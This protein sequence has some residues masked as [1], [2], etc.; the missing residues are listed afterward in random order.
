MLQRRLNQLLPHV[1]HHKPACVILD[2][3]GTIFFLLII[4]ARLLNLD[5]LESKA[6][7]TRA[8]F[9]PFLL[10]TTQPAPKCF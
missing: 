1:S 8:S 6:L 7:M 2:T 5:F 10:P 3:I 4:S 9:R